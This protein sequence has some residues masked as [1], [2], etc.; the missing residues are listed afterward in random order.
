MSTKERLYGL[1]QAPHQWYKKFE[2][3]MLEHGFNKTHADRC[4]FVKR[5]DEGDFL[6]LLLYV[7]DMLMVGQDTR[8]IGSLKK[9]LGPAKHISRMH[10]VR[11][12]TKNMLWLSQEKYV[13]KILE[14]FNM[15]EAKPIGSYIVDKLQVEYQT[16]PKRGEGQG[17]DEES[18]VSLGCWQFDVRYGLYKIRHSFCCGSNKPIYE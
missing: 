15:S 12:R 2:S 3:F 1:K 10:I 5:Y 14:R 4:V 16:M 7:D 8:K 18:I 6:I 13:T 11:D 17:R 9:D